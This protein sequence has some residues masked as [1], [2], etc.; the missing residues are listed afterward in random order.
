M[1]HYRITFQNDLK[2][3]FNAK[4]ISIPLKC[5]DNP[6]KMPQLSSLVCGIEGKNAHRCIIGK[7][8]MSSRTCGVPQSQAKGPLGSGGHYFFSNNPLKGILYFISPHLGQKQF[9]FDN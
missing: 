7:E 8:I 9:Y 3:L 5:H 4:N 2:G 1:L 6:S